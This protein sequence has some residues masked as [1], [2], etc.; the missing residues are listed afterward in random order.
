VRAQPLPQT[1]T[2][3]DLLGAFPESPG[4]PRIKTTSP[5]CFCLDDDFIEIYKSKYPAEVSGIHSPAPAAN[6]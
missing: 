1:V 3:I 4:T 6:I 2:Q 5:R